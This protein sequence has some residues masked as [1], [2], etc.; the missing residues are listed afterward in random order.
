M[1]QRPHRN[2]TDQFKEQAVNLVLRDKKPKAEVAR[3][4]DVAPSLLDQW[5]NRYKL[6]GTVSGP[7]RGSNNKNPDKERIKE[8]E[9][10]I[11]QL[12]L[13]KEILK[14]AAAYFAKDSV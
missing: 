7:G 4:L 1:K 9:A 11:R 2:Y 5:I 3:S 8:L 12:E 14:K 6:K 13:E 10:K